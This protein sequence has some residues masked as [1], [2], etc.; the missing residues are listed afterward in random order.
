MNG[1]HNVFAAPPSLSSD[2]RFFTSSSDSF[3][4]HHGVNTIFFWSNAGT[5]SFHSVTV[6][7]DVSRIAL[8]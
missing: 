5:K 3:V 4:S 8:A 1:M 2:E 7:V 6:I